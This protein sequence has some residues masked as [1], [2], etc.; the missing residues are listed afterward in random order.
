MSAPK[1]LRNSSDVF[2]IPRIE[3]QDREQFITV[4]IA[5]ATVLIVQMG[6]GIVI[7]N[8]LAADVITRQQFVEVPVEL[9]PHPIAQRDI[10]PFFRRS[11]VSRRDQVGERAPQDHF[12]SR[13]IQLQ[14]EWDVEGQLNYTRI[15]VRAP[16]FKPPLPP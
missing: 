2:A 9:R 16:K 14:V 3:D 4:V 13:P 15:Q 8:S 1:F 12:A 6:D 10:E 5:P 7:E 11:Q